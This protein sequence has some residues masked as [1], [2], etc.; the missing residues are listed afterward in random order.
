MYEQT[1]IPTTTTPDDHAP[2]SPS[3]AAS[4]DPRTGVTPAPAGYLAA[5]VGGGIGAVALMVA[6]GLMGAALIP[7]LEDPNGGMENLG[8]LLIPLALGALGIIGGMVLGVWVGLTKQAH[9][10]AIATASLTIPFTVLVLSASI[11]FLPG[12]A[13]LLLIGV[14]GM[15]RWIVLRARAS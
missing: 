12:G 9:P 4:I 1:S 11:G 8:L 15:A 2:P 6:G 10:G 14:P 13:P 5:M 3:T 7:I